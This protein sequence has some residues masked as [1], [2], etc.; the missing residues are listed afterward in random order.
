MATVLSY[1]IS[2]Y[3]PEP[4]VDFNS[5]EERKELT[6]SSLIMFF[7]M[8]KIWKVR[9]EDARLLLGGV[10]N[11]P[12]YEMK[13]QPKGKVLEVDRMYR[14]SYLLGIFKALNILHGKELADEWVQL[15][16]RNPMFAG[17]TPLQYMIEGNVPAM[18]N[19]RRLLDG[20]RGGV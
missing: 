2:R 9:D 10:S 8:M 4:L 19:V 18:A 16:N 15:P 20:R 12:F 13:K 14:V 1:P 11:G 6:P 3:T 17:K 5:F 7:N